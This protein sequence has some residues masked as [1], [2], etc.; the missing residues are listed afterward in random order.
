M[1]F[2]SPAVVSFDFLSTTQ[3]RDFATLSP[4]RLCSHACSRVVWSSPQA[5]KKLHTRTGGHVPRGIMILGM[6]WIEQHGCGGRLR[7]NE[8]LEYSN[9]FFKAREDTFFS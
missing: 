1:I 7:R 3:R 6:R 5:V 9:F 4:S 8:R 2:A